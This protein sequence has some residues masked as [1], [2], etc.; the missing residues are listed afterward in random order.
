[1][2]NVPALDK[3]PTENALKKALCVLKTDFGICKI[4]NQKKILAFRK[5][6]RKYIILITSLPYFGNIISLP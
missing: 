1:M 6:T 5:I 2:N 3:K 4:D